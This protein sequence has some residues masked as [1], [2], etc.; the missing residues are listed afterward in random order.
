[1]LHVLLSLL[2]CM[3]YLRTARR[4]R[5]VFESIVFDGWPHSGITL[6]FR[7]GALQQR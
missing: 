1:L 7:S 3:H 6:A 4:V 5:P 2:A